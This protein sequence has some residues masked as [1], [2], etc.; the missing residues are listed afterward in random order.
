MSARH[1][2]DVSTSGI[3]FIWIIFIDIHGT[4][5][6]DQLDD[7]SRCYWSFGCPQMVRK[8]IPVWLSLA[9]PLPR[10]INDTTPI[11]FEKY[12]LGYARS[13]KNIC[14]QFS[15]YENMFSF[16]KNQFKGAKSKKISI[17]LSAKHIRMTEY[18]LLAST[19]FFWRVLEHRDFHIL[20]SF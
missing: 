12:E 6:V 1:H 9:D 15:L 11:L 10:L 2:I 5:L 8:E 4:T 7:E 19:S 18:F 13:G 20:S 3:L 17:F 16:S 14:R